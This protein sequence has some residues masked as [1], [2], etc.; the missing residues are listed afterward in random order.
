MDNSYGVGVFAFASYKLNS[1]HSVQFGGFANYHPITTLALPAISYS[2]RARQSDGFK[3]ILGFPRTYAG[4]HLNDDTLLRIGVLFSQSVIRLNQT[5]AIEES[6]FIEA[7]DYMSSFGIKRELNESFSI[8]FDA[9]YS[10][11]RDFNVYSKN[12]RKLSEYSIK[13]SIGANFK[14]TYAF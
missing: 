9:L 4:Y 11:K 13:P 5:S 6:G 3:F 2:Y 1:E 14:V 8:N 12:G 7:Q 10:V